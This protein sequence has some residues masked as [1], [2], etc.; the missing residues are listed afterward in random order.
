[1][2]QNSPINVEDF[3][4]NSLNASQQMIESLSTTSKTVEELNNKALAIGAQREEL[5]SKMPDRYGNTPEVV[6]QRELAKAKAI[7]SANEF[8]INVGTNL[9]D[10]A[11]IMTAKTQQYNE[12]SD[13]LKIADAKV[14]SRAS[15]DPTKNLIGWLV[16]QFTL[17]QA[18]QEAD[19]IR[20]ERDDVSTSLTALNSITQQTTLTQTALAKT[21]TAATAQQLAEA[22][23]AMIDADVADMKLKNIGMNVQGI[24]SLR[25]L[26]YKQFNI[27][28][29]QQNTVLQGEQYKLSLKHLEMQERQFAATM[30]DR[31]ERLKEKQEDRAELEN[32]AQTMR[33]G[34]HIIGG[35]DLDNIP[36]KQLYAR[37]LR[38]DPVALEAFKVGDMNRRLPP[39][40][41]L[42][43]NSAGQA[44]V[45]IHTL[46]GKGNPQNQPITKLL[47]E[48]LGTAS[49]TAGVIK[50]TNIQ[51]ELKNKESVIQAADHFA[52]TTANS[53][54]DNITPGDPN[55]IYSIPSFKSIEELAGNALVK[56]PLYE[57]VLKPHVAA[58]MAVPDPEKIL[59]LTAVA[60]KDGTISMAEAVDNYTSLFSAA[61]LVN[62]R[63]R[64]YTGFGLKPQSDVKTTVDFQG[65]FGRGT[66]SNI[67]PNQITLNLSRRIKDMSP[68]FGF[69]GL[70]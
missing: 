18:I 32:T 41:N 6:L 39:N 21:S 15:Q 33:E 22:S 69:G 36:A 24:L 9:Q 51:V 55:N 60:I 63:V 16:A 45:T 46:G 70:R 5:A 48:S 53:M 30:Q 26:D 56:T 43:S 7:D 67:N 40:T 14:V 47:L 27:V 3:I 34:S 37:L 25:D 1:M 54:H 68:Q 38:N 52:K 57:K 17:P 50:G 49:T 59:A 12:I 8:A 62:N 10:A 2:A 44:A 35:M 65:A 66:I 58:G 31:M 13:R 19:A 64:N 61:Q 23:K 28:R 42:V 4:V 20:A 11:E 29:E